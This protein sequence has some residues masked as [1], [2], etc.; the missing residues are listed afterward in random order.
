MDIRREFAMH[1]GIEHASEKQ[2]SPPYIYD[3]YIILIYDAIYYYHFL[4]SRP[5]TLNRYA[6][7]ALE[8]QSSS[9]HGSLETG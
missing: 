9:K 8:T 3:I 5:F 4:L 7:G 2:D 6:D 1:S